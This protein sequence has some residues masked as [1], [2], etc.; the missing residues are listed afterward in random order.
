MNLNFHWE[1][2]GMTVVTGVA[3]ATSRFLAD[4]LTLFQP[5]GTYYAHQIILAPPSSPL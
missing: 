5:R 4:Q 3:M 2:K 1:I